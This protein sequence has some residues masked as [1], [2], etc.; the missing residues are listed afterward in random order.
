LVA[1][2]DG[3]LTVFASTDKDR[4]VGRKISLIASDAEVKGG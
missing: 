2:H 1:S 4:V 3:G